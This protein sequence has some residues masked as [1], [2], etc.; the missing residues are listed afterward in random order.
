MATQAAKQAATPI[1]G[2]SVT[3][4]VRQMDRAVNFY[5]QV[6]G[7]TVLYRAGDEFAMLD[8]GAGLKIGLHPAG[9]ES[10]PPGTNGASQIGFDVRGPIDEAVRELQ[11]RGVSFIER[12]GGPIVDDEAVKLAFFTDPDGNEHYLCEVIRT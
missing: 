4:F 6:L 12:D 2:G 11:S 10:P 7:L 8:A 3:V 5:A 9:P 1:R